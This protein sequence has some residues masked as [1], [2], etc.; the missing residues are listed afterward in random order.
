MHAQTSCHLTYWWRNLHTEPPPG[1]Q[2]CP[3]VTRWRNT[4]FVKQ[5]DISSST[6]CHYMR[7]YMPSRFTAISSSQ[8]GQGGKGTHPHHSQQAS[9]PPRRRQ[10][11]RPQRTEV[12]YGCF[13]T[14]RVR[15]EK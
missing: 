3:T 7:F 10:S 6:E 2:C 13:W 4:Q 1:W 8:S 9:L 15:G 12:K 14:D 11:Q 5:I